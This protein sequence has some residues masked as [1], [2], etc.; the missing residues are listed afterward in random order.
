MV[1]LELYS[2]HDSTGKKL[3]KQEM[4]QLMCPNMFSKEIKQ[5]PTQIPSYSL[6]F[7]IFQLMP[8]LQR[9]K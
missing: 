9:N 3:A 8:D 4:L 6:F 1:L 2:L 7:D 5:K